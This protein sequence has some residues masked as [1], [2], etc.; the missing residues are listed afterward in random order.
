M[1]AK[2]VLHHDDPPCTERLDN[3]GYCAKCKFIPDMQSKCFYFYC[4]TCDVMLE[5]LK[6]KN[7]GYTFENPNS[8]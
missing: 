7:C 2:M 1:K 5:N 8:S 4:P 3:D 6:C